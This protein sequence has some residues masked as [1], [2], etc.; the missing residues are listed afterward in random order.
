MFK[1]RQAQ[2]GGDSPQGFPLEASKARSAAR[3]EG[4]RD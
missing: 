1:G 4:V 2:R 3:R